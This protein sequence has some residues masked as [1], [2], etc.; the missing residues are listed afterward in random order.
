[1]AE[2]DDSSPERYHKKI[3]FDDDAENDECVKLDIGI[4]LS[5]NNCERKSSV[6]NNFGA[7]SKSS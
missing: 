6:D 1:M 5:K 3:T 7:S 2:G 4:N